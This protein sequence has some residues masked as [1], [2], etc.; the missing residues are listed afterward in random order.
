MMEFDD[1]GL[2]STDASVTE[3]EEVAVYEDV[4]ATAAVVD[5]VED[6]FL[7]SILLW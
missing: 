2:W 7:S 6:F 4:D 1:G 3:E 5:V